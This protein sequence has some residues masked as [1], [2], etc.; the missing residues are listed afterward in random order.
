MSDGGRVRLKKKLAEAIADAVRIENGRNLDTR[1]KLKTKQ[2]S[3]AASTHEA[4]GAITGETMMQ[5]ITA[6]QLML[7]TAIISA[8]ATKRNI[9]ELRQDLLMLDELNKEVKLLK[10]QVQA[11]VQIAT[12]AIDAV[13]LVLQDGYR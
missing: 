4:E 7:K 2:N 9:T 3:T 1:S 12:D 10:S 5:I 8:V 13:Q 6:I 11:Q